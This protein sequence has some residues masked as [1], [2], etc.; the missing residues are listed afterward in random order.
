[1]FCPYIYFCDVLTFPIIKDTLADKGLSIECELS[2]VNF[3]ASSIRI[4]ISSTKKIETI[5]KEDEC[6]MAFGASFILPI[7]GGH[8][9]TRL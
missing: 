5:C 3:S 9:K 2:K 4:G 6:I 7:G 8:I 1:M